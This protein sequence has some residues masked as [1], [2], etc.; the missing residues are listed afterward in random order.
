MTKQELFAKYHISEGHKVWEPAIDNWFSVEIYR[1]M[2][3]GELPP[4]ND[5]NILYVLDFIDKTNDPK[6]FF[7]LPNA[8]NLYTTAHRMIYR[9]ADEILKQ[10]AAAP[11]K[12][13]Q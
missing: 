5:S 4:P 12:E 1:V 11:N 9:Y 2:H 3:N 8:G 10:R 6:F 7:G 13:N